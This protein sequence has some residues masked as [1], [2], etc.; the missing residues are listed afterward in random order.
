M[1]DA[2]SLD[3]G[4]VSRGGS[5]QALL[6]RWD[7]REV[8][9]ARVFL[10][11]TTF[12]AAK[13]FVISLVSCDCNY[14]ITSLSR[15]TPFVHTHKSPRRKKLLLT[16]VVA[17]AHTTVGKLLGACFRRWFQRFSQSSPVIKYMLTCSS[18]TIEGTVI[19]ETHP[20]VFLRGFSPRLFGCERV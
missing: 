16:S 20:L 8:H 12:R 11:L 19:T 14:D 4:A 15:D 1:Q 7:V 3:F 6:P 18:L 5:A 13:R 9:Q 17:T 2:R 10:C